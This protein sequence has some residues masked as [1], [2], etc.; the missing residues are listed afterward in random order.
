MT[1]YVTIERIN[2]RKG[3]ADLAQ[4][5]LERGFDDTVEY[6]EGGWQDRSIETAYPHLKFINEQD[7]VA[8]VLAF[9]G[10]IHNKVPTYIIAGG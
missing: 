2:G 9:G 6:N 4:K 8:Y 3:L 10:V 1:V 7:A 5:L